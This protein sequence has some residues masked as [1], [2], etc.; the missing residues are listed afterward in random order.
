MIIY[1]LSFLL[2][3]CSIS[4]QFVIARVLMQF[5][6]DEILSQSITLGFYLV[7][8]G[9]GSQAAGFLKKKSERHTLFML[10]MALAL[11]GLFLV[12]LLYLSYTFLSVFLYHYLP[13]WTGWGQ[14]AEKVFLLQG[15]T[16]LVGFLTGMELPLLIKLHEKNTG[17]S[18]FNRILGINYLGAL[19]G[20]FAVSL[21]LIPLL[22]LARS[23]VLVAILNFIAT[24]IIAFGARKALWRWGATVV[25][26]ALFFISAAQTLKYTDVI[27]QAYIKSF[28]S[29]TRVPEISVRA[30]KNFFLYMDDFADVDR[31]VTPYQIIDTVPDKFMKSGEDI[32]DFSLYL[33]MQPQFS[34]L[35]QRTYHESM[36][37]GAINLSN[38]HPKEVLVLGAGDGLLVAELLKHTDIEKII[39]VELDPFMIRLAKEHKD[40][41]ELNRGSLYD[42]RVEVIIG[43]AFNYIRR[44]KKVF[45]G[46]FVDFPFPVSYELGKL[47]SVEFYSALSAVISPQGFFVADVP[48]WRGINAA[49]Q[50]PRPAPQDIVL[51]SLRAAG[52]NNAVVYGPI[53][54]FMFVSKKSQKPV[55]NYDSLS[56][57]LSNATLLNLTILTSVTDKAD[58]SEKNVNSIYRPRRFRW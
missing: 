30:V 20:S 39:L 52:F 3:F 12:P 47:F 25:A 53:E 44:T 41:K 35:T 17:K 13:F 32:G 33:N 43:D 31:Y 23:S 42:P 22:D 6:N 9:L 4:Y 18:S 2:S 50:R 54:A 57:W 21:Y 19:V 8:M 26:S 37:E 28:Y 58:V 29:E 27:E 16:L 11:V 14:G 24:V 51:S 1:L 10:E 40:I 7:A 55:F 56:P 34:R 36:V 5:S 38:T 48:I 45:D 49:D 15:C 46:V